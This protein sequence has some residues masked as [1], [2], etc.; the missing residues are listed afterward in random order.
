MNV[1][2]CGL[3]FLFNSTCVDSRLGPGFIFVVSD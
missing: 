1:I 3:V 2:R